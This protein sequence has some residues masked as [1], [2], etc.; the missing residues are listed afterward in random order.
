MVRVIVAVVSIF[1]SL[2]AIAATPWPEGIKESYID[3]CADSLSSQGLGEKVAKSYCS[4]IAN[5]MNNEFGLE[6]Y[7]SMMKAQPNPN[8]SNYDRRLYKVFSACKNYLPK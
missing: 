1:I 8:G 5:G 6:E 7:K 3:R 2:N 4:C